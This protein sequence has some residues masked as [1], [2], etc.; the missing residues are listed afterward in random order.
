MKRVVVWVALAILPLLGTTPAQ[1][2]YIYT[3][4]TTTA[5]GDFGLLNGSFTVAD[6]A[7]SDG[8]IDTAEI[9]SFSFSDDIFTFV[10]PLDAFAAS[11]P[12][13]STSGAMLNFGSLTMVDVDL[14]PPMP[15]EVASFVTGAGVVPY[16]RVGDVQALA[17][18]GSGTW[19]VGHTAIPE[20]SSIA[21]VAAGLMG[22]ILLGRRKR[23]IA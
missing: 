12:V 5:A 21:F 6:A 10:P 2:D 14:D 11:I 1:A 20:P 16:S 18:L 7:I 17:S 23:M 22:L 9:T 3:F 13:D 8:V 15:S 19:D 4:T